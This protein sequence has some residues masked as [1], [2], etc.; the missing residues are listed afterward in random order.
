VKTVIDFFF[1][2]VGFRCIQACH[3]DNNPASGRVMQK[4]G[5]IFEGFA[6]QDNAGRFDSINYAILAEDY[7]KG[8]KL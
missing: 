2:E 5:M 7:R 6:R 3:A 8:E 1:N 4:C